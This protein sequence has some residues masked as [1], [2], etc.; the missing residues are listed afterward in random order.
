MTNV[1]WSPVEFVARIL[2]PAEREVV[3]GDLL[4]AGESSWSS[5]WSVLGLAYRRQLLLW[6]G[7]RPWIASFGVAIPSCWLLMGVS[8][9]VTCTSVRLLRPDLSVMHWPTGHEGVLLLLCHLLLLVVWSWT[10]GFVCGSLSRKTLC[11]T[12]ALCLLPALFSDTHIS[13]LPRQWLFLFVLPA[14]FGLRE[15]LNPGRIKPFVAFGIA[16]GVTCLMTFAWNQ[17]AL[18]I[19]NWLLVLPVWYLVAIAGEPLE[20]ATSN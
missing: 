1:L 16:I 7:W 10:T 8:G 9:S 12:L 18:W 4:E 6:K 11:V 19:F 17:G 15:S 20:L 14:I 13:P 2:E 5:F 3:L